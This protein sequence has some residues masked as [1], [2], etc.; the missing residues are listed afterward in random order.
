MLPPG[1]LC[2]RPW[3]GD[4]SEVG[5]KA[6]GRPP[7]IWIDVEQGA[8]FGNPADSVR[9]FEDVRVCCA[10][11]REAWLFG[12]SDAAHIRGFYYPLA[13]HSSGG[14][15]PGIGPQMVLIDDLG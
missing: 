13:L 5:M 7:R 6:S 10:A 12:R 1:R 9:A 3:F 8:V 4:G 15:P 14:I 11:F 2:R